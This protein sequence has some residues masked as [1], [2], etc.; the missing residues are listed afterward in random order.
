MQRPYEKHA[1]QLT[2]YTRRARAR[3]RV[4]YVR[5]KRVRTSVLLRNICYL[6]FAS[7]ISFGI[8]MYRRPS[9]LYDRYLQLPHSYSRIVQLLSSSRVNFPRVKALGI[10][11]NDSVSSQLLIRTQS[12]KFRL[13]PILVRTSVNYTTIV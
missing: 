7:I 9:P 6:R 2:V 8:A 11:C 10:A 12:D 4:R 3:L 5:N 13:K 1:R